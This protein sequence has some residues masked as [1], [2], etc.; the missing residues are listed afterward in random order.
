MHAPAEK[1]RSILEKVSVQL[2]RT[3]EEAK[4]QRRTP[5]IHVQ[6]VND[7]RSDYLVSLRVDNVYLLPRE[8]VDSEADF[9]VESSEDILEFG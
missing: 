1:L 4:A 8:A 3:Y 5:K 6:V 7:K 9:G 2:P